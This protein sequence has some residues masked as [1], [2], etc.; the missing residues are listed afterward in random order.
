L[1]K[2]TVYS[3]RYIIKITSIEHNPRQK[4]DTMHVAK[5]TYTHY[6]GFTQIKNTDTRTRDRSILIQQ[7]FSIR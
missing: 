2:D 3:V 7:K 4:T 5:C 6:I 1:I